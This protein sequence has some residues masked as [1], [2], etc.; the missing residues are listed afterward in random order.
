MLDSVFAGQMVP[1]QRSPWSTALFALQLLDLLGKAQA[2]PL[3]IISYGSVGT[4]LAEVLALVEAY[5][6]AQ[7]IAIEYPHFQAIARPEVAEANREY[8][9]LA[10]R[11]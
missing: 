8:I 5:R 2:I 11:E 9:I 4:T 7:V 10:R 3:W 1:Y 6:P